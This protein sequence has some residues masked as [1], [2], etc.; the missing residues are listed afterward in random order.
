V[1]W[2]ELLS[3]PQSLGSPPTATPAART[4][5]VVQGA[6]PARAQESSASQTLLPTEARKKSPAA[7]TPIVDALAPRAGDG[8][9]SPNG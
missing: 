7:P 2:I 3:S 8:A 9:A 6:P 4:P 5:R 1:L